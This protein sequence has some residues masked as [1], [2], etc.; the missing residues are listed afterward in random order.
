MEEIQAAREIGGWA[1][2]AALVAAALARV[3][4]TRL[5]ERRKM[6]E[7]A[8]AEDRAPLIEAALRDFGVIRSEGLTR[9]QRFDLIRSIIDQRLKLYRVVAWALLGI[10][11]LGAVVMVAMPQVAAPYDLVVR[12]R[13][14]AGAAGP[15]EELHGQVRMTAGSLTAQAS[16]HQGEARFRSLPRRLVGEAAELEATVD[17]FG[18]TLL[19]DVRLPRAGAIDLEL[20]PPR[21]RVCGRIVDGEDQTRAVAGAGVEILGIRTV[22]DT[23]GSFCLDVAVDDGERVEVVVSRDGRIGYRGVETVSAKHR[24]TLLL[25]ATS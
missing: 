6:I 2:A 4:R 16:V 24:L 25:G 21:T 23:D 7:A 19:R 12:V 3:L 17:G 18:V 8:P 15:T 11:V 1:A 5:F 22:A 10:C 9:E 13:A 14:P 20:V